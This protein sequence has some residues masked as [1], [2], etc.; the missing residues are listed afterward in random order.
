MSQK[1]NI[2]Y[3][4]AFPSTKLIKS[5]KGKIDSLYR[6]TQTMIKALR[7][8]P[9]V[10]IKIITSP[11]I[12]SFPHN[13]IYFK[14]MYDDIDDVTMVSS[15]NISI[16][17]QM[18]TIF[19]MAKECIKLIRRNNDKTVI[20]IPYMVFRHVA[21]LRLI[22][23][24]CGKK[25]KACMV[26]PD[27]FFPKAKISK[28]LNN[29]TERMGR[30]NDYFILYTKSMA[31]YL[32]IN[33]KPYIVI[34]GY[35]DVIPQK[36][37]NNTDKLIVTYAGSLAI[38]YG[39]LRLV[40]AMKFIDNSDIELHI[41]GTGDADEYITKA[42]TLD[43]RIKFFGLVSKEK[44]TNVLFDSSVLV[45]PRSSS[46]GEYVMYSFPSKDIDYLSTGIPS[47]L[48]KLPGMP[49]SYYDFFIDAGN[50]TT[51]ELAE[52]IMKV[53]RMSIEERIKFGQR[54]LD[55]ITIQ[56]DPINQANKIVEMIKTD[57]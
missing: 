8:L 31:D 42:S 16:I 1:I 49:E 43:K 34:E 23:L 7:E 17:K 46:D 35:K 51:E 50:G 4:G 57:L 19:S 2:L 37:N 29:L 12:K 30:K 48:C 44:A 14:R 9:N 26:V 25:V 32:E 15:L 21:T 41:Y 13:K 3:L 36:I 18:W 11:D 54:A 6:A 38:K 27:I 28:F 45:N 40:D 47:I 53:Y 20:I 55:F 24:L 52:C 22:K 33:N 10:N 5:S 56:M 39:I